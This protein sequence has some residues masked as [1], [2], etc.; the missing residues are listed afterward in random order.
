MENLSVICAKSLEPI[1]LQSISAGTDPQKHLCQAPSSVPGN[2]PMNCSDTSA[3]DRKQAEQRIR[4]HGKTHDLSALTDAELFSGLKSLDAALARQVEPA[5]Q[6][7]KPAAS[8]AP[9][10]V[11]RP[12]DSSSDAAGTIKRPKAKAAAPVIPGLDLYLS[13]EVIPAP[14][15]VGSGF[16]LD[17]SNDDPHWAPRKKL[18]SSTAPVEVNA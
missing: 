13:P 14:S 9:Q 4:A 2:K 7:I 8:T 5:N 15:G 16:D 12:K 17:G 3:T 18:I 11:S 1:A 6:L 10:R